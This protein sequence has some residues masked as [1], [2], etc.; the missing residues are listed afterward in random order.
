MDTKS[1]K[2]NGAR[3]PQERPKHPQPWQ[4]DLNPDQLAGQNI[5]AGP[6][7]Q[8]RG[9]ATAYD[10]KDVHRALRAFADDELKQIPVLAPGTRLR[11]GATY[12]DLAAADRREFTATGEMEAGER[13]AYVPKD[14]VPY[15]IWNRLIG[16]PK[17]GQ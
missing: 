13:N 17:P 3:K 10:R 1:E 4:E 2:T 15:T 7:R 8:E 16:E 6:S 9:G 5:G 11:Q 12:V 14:E